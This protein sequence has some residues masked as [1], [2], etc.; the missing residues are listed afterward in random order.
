MKFVGLAP[1]DGCEVCG[2]MALFCCGEPWA[3]EVDGFIP[4]GQGDE[5]INV[6]LN[7]YRYIYIYIYIY[8]YIYIHIYIYIYIHIYI[9]IYIY[10]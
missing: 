6:K 9:C 4:M 3:L 2:N 8:T 7:I 10:T 5:G 1:G